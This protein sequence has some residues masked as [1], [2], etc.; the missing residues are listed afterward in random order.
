MTRLESRA[1][2]DTRV[3]A[4]DTRPSDTRDGII[5]I[6]TSQ[7]PRQTKVYDQSTGGWEN[8]APDEILVTDYA[9]SF[10]ESNLT[11]SH[12]NTRV[13]NEQIELEPAS[14][15]GTLQ[16]ND[17]THSNGYDHKKGAWF[18]PKTDGWEGVR[19]NSVM[20]TDSE[21]TTLYLLD[22]AGN[23]LAEKSVSPYNTPHEITA[24]TPL[25][26]GVDYA[27]A[28]DAGTSNWW[29]NFRDVSGNETYPYE[30]TDFTI[31]A[32]YSN[33]GQ[34]SDWLWELMDLELYNGPYN[35]EATVQWDYPD[36]FGWDKLTY[37]ALREN[38]TVDVYV[39]EY[40]GSSWVEAA[41][42]MSR[43][44]EIP[45]TAD[46]NMRFR[47]EFFRESTANA[48]ILESIARRYQI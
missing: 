46:R 21:W 2:A 3:Y 29:S 16:P 33:G 25:E 1:I 37:Q 8:I 43:G 28:V 32:G 48:P 35:G 39:E 11:V 19:I 5:W 22:A 26:A 41:G 10:A 20:G 27:V 14:S 47:V 40:D 24:K 18:R 15:T 23:V 30:N 45:T 12:F 17:S 34:S 6:D 13:N 44:D 9:E 42:P 4:Q 38:E 31:F 36:V 7:T